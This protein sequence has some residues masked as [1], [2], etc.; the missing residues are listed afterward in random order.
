M[1]LSDIERRMFLFSETSGE[2]DLE[3]NEKFD[4]EYDSEGYEKKIASLLKKAY[5]NA[6]KS[7][8]EKAAWED[9]LSA[10][11]KEDFYGLVM[12][13]A[14]GIPRPLAIPQLFD[15]RLIVFLLTVAAV[16]GIAVLLIFDPF[17]SNWIRP[18]WPRLALIPIFLGMLW[19]LGEL[20][21]RLTIGGPPSR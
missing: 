18:G 8:P 9:A 21:K 15:K 7:A 14:A 6:C 19:W 17:H 4:S 12:V 5:R 16:I 10:L 13:D 11:Q 20:H 2:A 3:A 1:K